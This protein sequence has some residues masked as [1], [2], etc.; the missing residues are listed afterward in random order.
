MIF[1]TDTI[2]LEEQE[3]QIRQIHASGPGGQH[4]NKVASAVHLRF[5]VSA[6]SLP[7]RVKNR[8]LSMHDARVSADG[9][10]VIK[11]QRHKSLEKNREDALQRLQLLISKALVK[12]RKRVPTRP[13]RAAR[14]RRLEVK[15]QQSRRKIQRRKVTS[16]D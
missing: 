10:V 4:V 13:S 15:Q 1:I 8:L 3:V 9:I 5:D 16:F 14:E 7:D 6:S 11:A 12:P 2:H